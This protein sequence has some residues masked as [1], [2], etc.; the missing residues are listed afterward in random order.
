MSLFSKF[1]KNPADSLAVENLN[2]RYNEMKN[3]KLETAQKY[4]DKS[5]FRHVKNNIYEDLNDKD[6]TKYRMTISYELESEDNQYP[7]ED[8]LEKFYLY[9]SDF[10][11]SEHDSKHGFFME[12]LAGELNDLENAQA[13]IG[14][15]VYN[16]DYHEGKEVK[17]RLVIE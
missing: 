12:E 1:F 14:K 8:I 15:T 6:D 5:Q 11:E 16:Q 10:L 7:L 4:A 9:V 17:V 3:I 13:I 2:E